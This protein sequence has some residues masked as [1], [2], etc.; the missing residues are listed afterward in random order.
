MDFNFVG[1]FF[2][3]QGSPIKPFLLCNQKALLIQKFRKFIESHS[4][5]KETKFFKIR[6]FN[7]TCS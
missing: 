3:F 4:Y 5:V 6:L 1:T 7:I 2:Q